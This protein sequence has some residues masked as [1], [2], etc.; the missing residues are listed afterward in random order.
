MARVYIYLG[1]YEECAAGVF[2]NPPIDFIFHDGEVLVHYTDPAAPGTPSQVR[3]EFFQRY[4]PAQPA[5]N[6]EH[7]GTVADTQ[8]GVKLNT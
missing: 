5:D 7:G 8:E 1:E 3:V 2:R 4:T 6:G